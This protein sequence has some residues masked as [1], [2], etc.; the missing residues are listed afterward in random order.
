MPTAIVNTNVPS[1]KIKDTDVAKS[2][3]KIVA[4]TIGKPEQYVMTLVQTDQVMTYSG[5]QEPCAFVRIVSIGGLNAEK[6][7]TISTEVCGLLES[8]YK[9]DPSRVYIEFVDSERHMFGWNS[10]TF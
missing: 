3:S 10:R 1:D 7:V 9:I 2:L 6:N 8:Q 5:T 4:T